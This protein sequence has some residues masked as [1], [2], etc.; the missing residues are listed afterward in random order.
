MH[1]V[2]RKWCGNMKK[3]VWVLVVTLLLVLILGLLCAWVSRNTVSSMKEK[4][5]L[6]AG[7]IQTQEYEEALE[8]TKNLCSQWEKRGEL[9]QIWTVHEDADEVTVLLEILSVS[10]EEKEGLHALLA[11]AELEQSIEHLYHRD[12]LKLQNFF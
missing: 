2:R 1:F 3:T 6:I 12:A 10:L 9:L 11:C 5:A 4:T 8:E 7:L